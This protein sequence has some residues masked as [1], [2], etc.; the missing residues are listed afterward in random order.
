MNMRETTYNLADVAW[1][2]EDKTITLTI[3]LTHFVASRAEIEFVVVHILL[4]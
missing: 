1:Y 4:D 2:A 3:T